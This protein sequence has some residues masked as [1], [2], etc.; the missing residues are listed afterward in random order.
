MF[1]VRHTGPHEVLPPRLSHSARRPP[2]A[3]LR[4]RP[5][6]AWTPG[7][8][9]RPQH[10]L[11]ARDASPDAGGGHPL[12][13]SADRFALPGF[14]ETDPSVAFC[15]LSFG[16]SGFSRES[17]V[18]PVLPLGRIPLYG[19][20]AVRLSVQVSTDTWSCPVS[21]YSKYVCVQVL[22]RT[23]VSFSVGRDLRG[24]R[25]DNTAGVHLPA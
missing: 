24:E 22:V 10:E 13:V 7:P 8:H 9:C 16:P 12:S 19:R 18:R 17:V 15:L 2:P 4:R 11:A 14:P 1:A 21:S 23:C 3:L 6:H 5:R 20:T 25:L